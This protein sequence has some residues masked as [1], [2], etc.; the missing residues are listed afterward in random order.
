[1]DKV[2][3]KYIRILP[4]KIHILT[5]IIVFVYPLLL[6]NAVLQWW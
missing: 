4:S 3:Q 5:S 6:C 1:M 2:K